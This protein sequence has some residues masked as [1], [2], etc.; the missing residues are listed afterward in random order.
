MEVEAPQNP[1]IALSSAPIDPSPQPL[2]I[3]TSEKID[4]HTIAP[5]PVVIYSTRP[6]TLQNIG[7]LARQ[8]SCPHCHRRGMT[9]TNRETS[10][11]QWRCFAALAMGSWIFFWIPFC[12]DDCYN[13][14][15]RC[16]YCNNTIA[17]HDGNKAA[18]SYCQCCQ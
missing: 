15:H 7:F 14:T 3:I 13:V 17:K 11:E 5:Q 10:E 4:I 16:K 9:V 8:I 12:L 6:E 1:E 18:K 2:P